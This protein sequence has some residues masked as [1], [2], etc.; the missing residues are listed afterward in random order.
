LI[1]LIFLLYFFT[2]SLAEKSNDQSAS[3]RYSLR[4]R[5]PVKTKEVAEMSTHAIAT[6]EMKSWDEKPYNETEG[7]PKLT[8]ASVAKS[9]KGDIE[10]EGTLEYL[11]MY[12]TDGSASFIGLE[13]L[14]GRLGGRAG[15]FVLQHSGT[16]EGGVAKATYF[17]VP[18]SG[19][20][21]LHGLRGEGSFAS[22]HAQQYPI[23]LDYD[24]E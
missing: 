16:F 12:R 2:L 13:R 14:V 10:G 6:F 24:F 11:M 7:L 18:G 20:G 1:F 5:E 3:W 22:G 4:D 15:S 9:F 17:V 21:E 23:T 19:T 8:R